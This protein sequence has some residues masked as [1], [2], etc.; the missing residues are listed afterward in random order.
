M[1]IASYLALYVLAVALLGALLAPPAYAVVQALGW[2]GIPFRRVTDRALLVVALL[3]LPVLLRRLGLRRRADW[4]YGVAWRPALRAAAWGLAGGLL[5]LGALALALLALGV[6]HWSTAVTPGQV[7]AALAGGLLSGV[8]IGL[9]EET[10]FRGALYAVWRQQA[11]V[12]AAVLATALMYAAVH[13]LRGSKSI[14]PSGWSAGFAYLYAS[15]AEI[16]Q[17]ERL[18]PFL[19]LVAVGVLLALVRWRAGHIAW[20]IGLHAG[21]VTTIKLARTCTQWDGQAPLAWLAPNTYDGL[22]GYLAFTWLLL[23]CLPLL[24]WRRPARAVEAA[25]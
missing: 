20:G 23:L 9:I 7:A 8:A 22:T 10:F 13:F 12:M 6:R 4:G 2:T 5:S 3:L 15:L 14:T 17:M 1:R 11:G 25:P 19:A 24:L 18:G 16:C 21:W